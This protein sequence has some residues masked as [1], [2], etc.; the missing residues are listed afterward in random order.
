[1]NSL[2]RMLQILDL[3]G[4]EQSVVDAESICAQ[5]AFAPATAYRY[6]KELCDAGLLTRF[7][8]GYA[9]GPRII[10]LDLLM[11]DHDPLVAGSRDL[12]VEIVE[13]TGMDILLSQLYGDSV[14]S[15]HQ[16]SR[17]DPFKLKFGRGKAMGL[18]QNATG[19]VILAHLPPRKLRRIFDEHEGNAQLKRL[20]SDWKHFSRTLRDIRKCGYCIT[21]GEADVNL[22]GVAAAIFDEQQRVL[23]SITLL[24]QRERYRAFNEDYLAELA[25]S[26]AAK[27]SARISTSG[28]D[29]T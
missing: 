5:L 11:R 16:Q 12:M 21:H 22:S 8:K 18:F 3:F 1:M 13:K 27:I 28:Q 24:A 10:E 26:T 20:G 2:R 15:V 4:P 6:I 17:G 14:V 7:P 9:L 29:S 25:T 19:R 23:G